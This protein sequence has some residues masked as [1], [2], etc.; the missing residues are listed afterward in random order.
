MARGRDSHQAR[1]AATS[2]LGKTL[3]RR[4]RSKCELCGDSDGL[5]VVEVPPLPEEP[6]DDS[7]LLAC[8]RCRRNLTDTLD[9][10]GTLRFL[11]NAV[12]EELLP[13]RL[14]AYILVQRLAKDEVQWAKALLEQVW[15][16][17]DLQQRLDGLK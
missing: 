14:A 4:A 3:T 16:D 2:A 9:D 17:E 12:W 10:A 8:E 1:L 5:K 13:S 7:A 11:E 6:S 15:V